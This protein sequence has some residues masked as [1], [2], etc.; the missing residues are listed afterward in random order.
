VLPGPPWS[1]VRQVHGAG[2][3]DAASPGAEADVLVASEGGRLAVFAADCALLAVA[4]AEGPFAAVHAGWAG[5]VA[6]VIEAAAAELRRRGATSLRAVRGPCIGPECYEFT[7]ADLDRVA[8]RYGPQVR[9]TTSAG[10]PALDLAAG[11]RAACERAGIELAGEVASCTACARTADGEPLFFSHR[12]RR[13]T[14][15]HALVV[16]REP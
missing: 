11:V 15:R 1:T 7:P 5:L 2:V 8:S 10:T 16:A 4:S 9:G 6:G 12:A 13:D 3:A 14:G